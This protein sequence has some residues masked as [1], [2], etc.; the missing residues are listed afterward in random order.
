M[1][2]FKVKITSN[3]TTVRKINV[4][5]IQSQHFNDFICTDRLLFIV[6]KFITEFFIVFSSVKCNSIYNIIKKV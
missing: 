5:N 2:R 1:L 6:E 4:A 3:T